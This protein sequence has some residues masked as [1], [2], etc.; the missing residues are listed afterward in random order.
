MDSSSSSSSSAE[1]LSESSELLLS[2]GSTMSTFLAACDALEDTASSSTTREYIIRF[3]ESAQDT[4]M[5]DYFVEENP[6]FPAHV[7]RERFRM[8]KS[9][10][11]KIVGDIEAN[12]EWFQEGI[13][14]RGQ[15][16]FTALQKCT[17][18]IRQLS[19]GGPP[20]RYDD[21]LN[22]ARRT[23]G[24]FFKCFRF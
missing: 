8:N 22:M 14:A 15:K 13:D 5:N 18:A 24:Y 20:D 2:T 1:L 21:Y 19:T 12:V 23:S 6:K 3:R 16:S 4:L 10:F 7:F 9:L 11:L 17:S